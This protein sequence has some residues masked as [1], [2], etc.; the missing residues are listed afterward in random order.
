MNLVTDT[1]TRDWQR[2]EHRIRD[3]VLLALCVLLA[4][5]ASWLAAVAF[6]SLFG[7]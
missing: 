2:S 5:S 3:A 6:V 7:N 1:E 4:C